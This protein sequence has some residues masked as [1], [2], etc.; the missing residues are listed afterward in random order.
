MAVIFRSFVALS[1]LAS[2]GSAGPV[3][4]QG[5]GVQVT[6]DGSYVLVSKDVGEERWAITRNEDGTVTGNVFFPE[7]GDPKFVWC[8]EQDRTDEEVTL[9]CSGA[10]RCT[11]ETCTIEDWTFL[12]EVTVPISFFTPTPV[13]GEALAVGPTAPTAGVAGGSGLQ[14]TPD[15]LRVLVSKDVG[16]ERWAITRNLTDFTVTGNV[17]FPDGGDPA[18]VWCEQLAVEDGIITLRCEGADACV[19]ECTP[20]SWT[21]IGE[22]ELPESFFELRPEGGDITPENVATLVTKWNHPS[23]AV[24][25]YPILANGLL[26][27]TSWDAKLYALDPETGAERWVFNTNTAGFGIE[28]TVKVLEDGDLVFGDWL[29]NVYRLDGLTGDV[30]WQRQIADPAVDHIWSAVGIAD[31]RI[32]VG[33]ASHTDNPCTNG[34]TIA[35]DL[36]TGE[37]LWV[38]QNVPDRICDS[39]TAVACEDDGDCDGGTCVEARGAGVTAEPRPSDD[40]EFV[41]VNTVGCYTFPSVG[42]S[43]SMMKLDA[44]TGEIIWLTR[45]T[46]PEQF[47]YCE[48]DNTVD[49]APGT[50]CDS[51]AECV[52]K[53]FYHDYGFLNGPLLIA[54]RAPN[55]SERTLVISG[56]KDGALYA[57]DE[58]DGSLEW[59]NRLVP[60]PV[61]PGFAGFGLFNGALAY[62]GEKLYAA[63]YQVIPD[64]SPELERLV[65]FD[66]SDGSVVWTGDIGVSWAHAGVA[67]G[68]VYAGAR[69]TES[70]FAYD[71]E[72]GERLAE[73]P[74]PGADDPLLDS[75]TVSRPLVVGD[76]LFVGYGVASP[77]SGGVVALTLP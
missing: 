1:L 34:R 38:Q 24:T 58:Q 13:E 60:L 31:G 39:D 23:G 4:A 18:F 74:L 50:T 62:D 35:L 45:V 21:E 29:T 56:S 41:Y 26:Y 22:V 6:P 11:I 36:D 63:L 19:G 68:V 53:A 30:V 51:G 46:P 73:L 10:D 77:G 57:F 72:S 55:G 37:E 2:L 3:L 28:A 7:G 43:D 12:A 71:A 54:T 8:E 20:D 16:A 9:A 48:D 69:E 70:L 64:V 42:N 5:S 65:A 27:V 40:G 25:S 67:N 33:I 61:S 14:I 47:G 76:T 32:F 15:E 44:E 59:E 75:E 66:P 49:C 52:E 17:F